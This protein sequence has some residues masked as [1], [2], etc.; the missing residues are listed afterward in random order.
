MKKFF[1]NKK[2]IFII[3]GNGFIGSE[4]VRKLSKISKK[5]IILDIKN[6]NNKF[7]NTIFEKFDCADLNQIKKNI[8]KLNMII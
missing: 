6:N 8:S 2:C 4:I 7:K 5:I 3:G 1:I